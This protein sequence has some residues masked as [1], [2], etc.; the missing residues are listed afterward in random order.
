MTRLILYA[1]GTLICLAV[2]LA[3]TAC[4][5]P[6]PPTVVETVREVAVLMTVEV[7]VEV[8]RVVVIT[9]TS[10]PTQLGPTPTTTTVPVGRLLAGIAPTATGSESEDSQPAPTNVPPPPTPVPPPPLVYQVVGTSCT[11]WAD[12]LG[13]EPTRGPDDGYPWSETRQGAVV[14]ESR[15]CWY[16]YGWK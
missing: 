10:S 5:P 4:S 1:V 14:I 7:E 13:A 9:A 16:V 8:T 2:I 15:W 3:L 12:G 11:D 6:V